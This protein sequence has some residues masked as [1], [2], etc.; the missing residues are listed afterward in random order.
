MRS[1]SHIL[2]Q[3]GLRVSEQLI[4]QGD[5]RPCVTRSTYLRRQF[6]S[7]CF[8]CAPLSRALLFHITPFPVSASVINPLEVAYVAIVLFLPLQWAT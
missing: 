6:R 4:R 2:A 5:S 1:K 7:T 8:S 3:T